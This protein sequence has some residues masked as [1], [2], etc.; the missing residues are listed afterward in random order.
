[1]CL[2]VP[3]EKPT[4]DWADDPSFN[5]LMVLPPVDS[6]ASQPRMAAVSEASEAVAAAARYTSI[7]RMCC[8][9]T[10]KKLENLFA[11]PCVGL[12]TDAPACNFLI[13]LQALQSTPAADL[14]PAEAAAAAEPGAGEA[15]GP[16][17]VHTGEN[18]HDKTAQ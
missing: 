1:M 8:M 18:Q 17:R 15:G 7:R 9:L 16:A 6:Q 5:M 10:A 4:R 3:F 14:R 11:L 12:Q 13:G 2:L